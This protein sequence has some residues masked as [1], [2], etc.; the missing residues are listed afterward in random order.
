MWGNLLKGYLAK[1]WSLM[2]QYEIFRDVRDQH[3]GEARMMQIMV[4][5]TSHV[6]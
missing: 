5:I 3:K 1:Q 2:R 6:R 4:A